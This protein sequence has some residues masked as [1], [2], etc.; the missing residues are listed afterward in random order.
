MTLGTMF[1]FPYFSKSGVAVEE[2]VSGLTFE[3]KS[4]FPC[5]SLS[6][7]DCEVARLAEFSFD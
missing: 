1:S 5:C 6:L 3:T 7:L 4:S 2:S